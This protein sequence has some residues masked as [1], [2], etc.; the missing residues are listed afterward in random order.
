MKKI[1]RI[2]VGLVILGLLAFAVYKFFI[3][4]ERTNTYYEKYFT[5][6][7]MDYAV[8]EDEL[9]VKLLDIKDDRCLDADCDREGQYLVKLLVVNS[10]KIA[11]VELGTLSPTSVELDIISLEYTLT[12]IRVDEKGAT[13][14]VAPNED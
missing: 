4:C 14:T 6:D 11:Y 2:I 12:L 7:E 5:L 13:L 9:I 10:A 3:D 1:I 8:I